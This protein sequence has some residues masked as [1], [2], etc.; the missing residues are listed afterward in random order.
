MGVAFVPEIDFWEVGT[1][2]IVSKAK[3]KTSFTAYSGSCRRQKEK[4]FFSNG[5]ALIMALVYSYTNYFIQWR[6]S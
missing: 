2:G 3:L 6:L 1:Y 5:I 4:E